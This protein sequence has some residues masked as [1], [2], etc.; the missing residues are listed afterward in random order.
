MADEADRSQDRLELEDEIRKRYK[1][2]VLDGP[3]ATGN[4]LNCGDEVDGDRRWCSP[5]CRE[6]WGLRNKV[7]R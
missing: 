6:D 2:V 4:C 5:E 3:K 7:R 1:F